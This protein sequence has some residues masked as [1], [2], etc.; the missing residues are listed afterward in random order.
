MQLEAVQEV[1]SYGVIGHCCSNRGHQWQCCRVCHVCIIVAIGNDVLL[2]SHVCIIVA[3]GMDE[4]LFGVS[5][6]K[7]V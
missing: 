5:L 7:Q 4:L 3:I 6:M 1:D 2:C